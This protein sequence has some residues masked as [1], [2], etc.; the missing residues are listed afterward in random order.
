MKVDS[1]TQRYQKKKKI[2]LTETL[3]DSFLIKFTFL[4]NL[5]QFLFPIK[6]FNKHIK[7]NEHLKYICTHTSIELI[8]KSTFAFTFTSSNITHYNILPEFSVLAIYC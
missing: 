4:M 2:T 5:S 3:G 7:L 8:S 6:S 1:Y